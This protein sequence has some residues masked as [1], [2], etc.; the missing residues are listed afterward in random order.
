MMGECMKHPRQKPTGR[1]LTVKTERG[2]RAAIACR[3]W[4]P[5]PRSNPKTAAGDATRKE[6]GMSNTMAE[7]F[8]E[9]YLITWTEHGKTSPTGGTETP[10]PTCTG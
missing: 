8:C 10:S 2:A 4:G 6:P 7:A 9:E 3:R 1:R 5:T